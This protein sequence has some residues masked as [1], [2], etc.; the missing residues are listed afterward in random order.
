MSVPSEHRTTPELQFVT[1]A[2]D[3]AYKVEPLTDRYPSHQWNSMGI[4]MCQDASNVLLNVQ[5]VDAMYLRTDED[6]AEELDRLERAL[7]HLAHL[8][9]MTDMSIRAFQRINRDVEEKQAVE[10]ARAAEDPDYKPRRFKRKGPSE[11]DIQIIADKITKE[12][13][14]IAG[15]KRKAP[16]LLAQYKERK[17]KRERERAAKERAAEEAPPVAITPR[18]GDGGGDDQQ[19]LFSV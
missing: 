7:G 8:E 16:K 18:D 10:D 11:N 14:L 9:V 6:L 1:T 4:F 12:R 19:T 17:A 13:D 15:V 3:I 2:K 5:L